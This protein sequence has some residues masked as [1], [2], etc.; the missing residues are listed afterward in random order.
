M[1]FICTVY[2]LILF[3]LLSTWN[4]LQEHDRH[5]SYCIEYCEEQSPPMFVLYKPQISNA[6]SSFFQNGKKM[7]L[8]A[9]IVSGIY[10]HYRLM[11]RQTLRTNF[12]RK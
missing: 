8:K 1:T 5:I 2:I 4:S 7:H 9:L 10:I 12:E 11:S 3:R 6:K